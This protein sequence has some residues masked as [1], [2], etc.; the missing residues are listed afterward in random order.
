MVQQGAEI[1]PTNQ[2]SVLIFFRFKYFLKQQSP[3]IDRNV[4]RTKDQLVVHILVLIFE[5]VHKINGPNKAI[6]MML[7][8]VKRSFSYWS[9]FRF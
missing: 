6:K 8:L 1:S 3:E 4:R 9:S 5:E 7:T 2:P